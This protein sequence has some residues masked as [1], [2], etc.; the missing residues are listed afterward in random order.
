LWEGSFGWLD[1]G[2]V[3]FLFFCLFV[4]LDS[5]SVHKYSKKQKNK[6]R[7]WPSFSHLEVWPR[8]SRIHKCFSHFGHVSVINIRKTKTTRRPL[9]D[10]RCVQCH[11]MYA[12]SLKGP[13]K[14]E[15]RQIYHTASSQL[16]LM[17]SS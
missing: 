1:I 9:L 10:M 17:L 4:D 11:V 15:R 8:S 6:K 7:S 13:Y 16:M 3:F 14:K 12:L 2:L 5:V